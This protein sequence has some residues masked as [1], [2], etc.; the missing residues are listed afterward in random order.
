[1]TVDSISWK[2][3]PTFVCASMSGS[4]VVEFPRLDGHP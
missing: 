4:L 3:S 1:M 2:L